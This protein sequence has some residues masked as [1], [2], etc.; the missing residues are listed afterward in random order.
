MELQN[1]SNRN[2][3][4]FENLGFSFVVDDIFRVRVPLE[5][6]INGIYINVEV[7]LTGYPLKQ[8]VLKLLSI[9]EQYKLYKSIQKNWR[10]I[11]EQM[12]S[13]N[14]KDSSFYICAIHNWSASSI[15]NANFIY[16]RLLDWLNKNQNDDWISEDDLF[17]WRIL[18][19][20]S[21]LILYLDQNFVQEFESLEYLKF[22]EFNVI[23]SKYR[24]KKGRVSSSNGNNYYYNNIDFS[25][26][27]YYFEDNDRNFEYNIIKQNL[28]PKSS[29]SITSKFNVIRLPRNYKFKSTYQL[30]HSLMLNTDIKQVME[31]N[32]NS[33]FIIR[34]FGDK[35]RIETLAFITD[36]NSIC[37]NTIK[38]I[39]IINIEII[40][41][42][43]VGIDQNIG[44][45]GVGS[46][47]SQISK[48]LSHKKV[49][50]LVLCD[51]DRLS[52]SNLG[53]HEL[54]PYFLGKPKAQSLALQLKHTLLQRVRPELSDSQEIFNF[55]DILVVTVGN[56]Q[57]LD[58][59][60]FK[61]LISYDKPIIW[62]WTS[63]NNILQEI[64]ITRP[65][66][67]C[68]NCYYQ[69]IKDD[70][71]L[72]SLHQKAESEIKLYPSEGIDLCGNPHTIST[73]EKMS[74]LSSQ[75]TSIISLYS[76]NKRF[77]YDYYNYYWGMDEIMPTHMFGFLQQQKGCSCKGE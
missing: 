45:L 53:N 43:L 75:I 12:I 3:A 33:P 4:E 14:P 73:W 55:C 64:V 37:N 57:S 21:S 69:L 67:G 22:Y 58:R 6:D 51:F 62:A 25:E 15:Y 76:K 35:G 59:L 28:V 48:M 23:H 30:L 50:E 61:E 17:T 40:S 63:P 1:N 70:A 47:G 27:Y 68:L 41:E 66:T 26:T 34:Y 11:D 8:P 13:D 71:I 5:G 2:K 20:Y 72:E 9:N 32:K 46:L 10:H 49:K 60:A 39:Q 18:P 74:F 42:N 36:S 65:D 44:I 56:K 16:E 29:N 54:P 31:L 52:I 77:K 7:D 24:Q 19:Q 38:S